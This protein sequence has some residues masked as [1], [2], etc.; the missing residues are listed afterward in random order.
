MTSLRADRF[1]DSLWS[2]D[3]GDGRAVR[4]DPSSG[5]SVLG[6]LRH[7]RAKLPRMRT[8]P[9]ATDGHGLHLSTQDV[10]L[11][12]STNTVIR[13]II[14]PSRRPRIAHSVES[15]LSEPQFPETKS[16]MSEAL[17][18][19]IGGVS[20]VSAYFDDTENSAVAVVEAIGAP[21]PQLTTYATASLH[22]IAN[23][24]N[25][26]DVRVELILVGEAG[27]G[28]VGNLLATAAFYVMKNRWLA[29]PGVVFPDIVADFFPGSDVR[30]IMWVPPFD[31]GT[32]STFAVQGVD[33][34][35]HALQGV[36]ITDRERALLDSAG[37]MVLDR[38]LE[39]ANAP[40]YDFGRASVV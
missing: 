26:R 12:C 29:A 5:G 36:P 38:E 8:G 39:R 9:T 2:L 23:L 13:A 3:S 17:G 30:H 37:F 4:T 14:V 31:F 34:S 19:A 6:A 21:S 33:P 10:P 7:A 24:L 35:V 25:G 22:A 11:C 18:R 20:T 16:A 1:Q 15:I 40:H 32:L 27:L 28:D